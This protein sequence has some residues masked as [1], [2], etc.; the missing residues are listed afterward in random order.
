MSRPIKVFK[1][2]SCN[3]AIFENTVQQEDRTFTVHSVSLQRGYQDK[4]G[5]WKNVSSFN[6]ND[7]PKILV[8][9][10]QAYEWIITKGNGEEEAEQPSRNGNGTATTEHSNEGITEQQ[11]NAIRRLNGQLGGDEE[12][13]SSL[14]Q[15]CKAQFLDELTF[16]EAGNIIRELSKLIDQTRDTASAA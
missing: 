8:A 2:G 10:Q 11:K 14:L 16:D 13:V 5:N 9:A 3:A 15:D 7:I 12:D 6:M 4:D 1:A